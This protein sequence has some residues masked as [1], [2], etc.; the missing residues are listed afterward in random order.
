MSKMGEEARQI[1]DGLSFEETGNA[2][3]I[4]PNDFAGWEN[5]FAAMK[6]ACAAEWPSNCPLLLLQPKQGRIRIT[7]NGNDIGRVLCVALVAAW[8]IEPAVLDPADLRQRV[9]SQPARPAQMQGGA[10]PN[11]APPP[12]WSQPARPAQMQGGAK[13]DPAPPPVPSQPAPWAPDNNRWKE[14]S[15]TKMVE[16]IRKLEEMSGDLDHRK[17]ELTKVHDALE[18]LEATV[19]RQA[20]IEYFDKAMTLCEDRVGRFEKL[21]A[22]FELEERERKERKQ[23]TGGAEDLARE[24]QPWQIKDFR[25]DMVWAVNGMTQWMEPE[26]DD[27]R[28]GN[29]WS[30]GNV[31]NVLS[32]LESCVEAL[33]T[34][35]H[36]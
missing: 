6:D 18:Q 2:V 17:D 13:W 7:L 20:H 3:N 27:V 1:L 15:A 16:M 35:G 34:E 5:R 21:V 19:N 10:K 23:D 28:Q 14:E 29:N 31:L 24:R 4:I 11:P 26:V 22:E 25:R 30:L 9:K 8:G 33:Q 12:V 36:E 32:H